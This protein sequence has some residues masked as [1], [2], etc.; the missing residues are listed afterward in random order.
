MRGRSIS[1]GVG[2]AVVGLLVAVQAWPYPKFAHETKVACASCHVNPAGGVDLTAAGK[3]YQEDPS[4]KPENVAGADYIG[5]TKCKMCHSKQ[6]ASWLETPHAKALA[7]LKAAP[8]SSVAKMASALKVELKGSA[9]DNDNCVVC[10]VTGFQ[11]PGGYPAADSAK[12]AAVSG[13]T[14]EACHGPGSKHMSA[15]MA[16][17]KNFINRNVTAN[18]CMQCH[19]AVTSPKFDFA[20]WKKRVH[21]MSVKTGK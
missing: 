6:H 1:W 16:Q 14:C 18:M 5:N 3:A 9:A 19:T 15:P 10:H 7:L 4:K 12:T 13:V 8:D 21:V 11:L 17:K 2:A 20:E